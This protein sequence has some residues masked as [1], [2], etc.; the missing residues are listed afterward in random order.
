MSLS[1]LVPKQL[2]F[3][4]GNAWAAAENQWNQWVLTY[5]SDRQENWVKRLSKSLVKH[6]GL[7]QFLGGGRLEVLIYLMVG[8]LLLFVLGMAILLYRAGRVVISPLDS[9]MAKLEKTYLDYLAH[10]QP[11]LLRSKQTEALKRRRAE[12]HRAWLTRLSVEQPTSHEKPLW[13]LMKQFEQLKYAPKEA[14]KI[15]F[16]EWKKQ[17][18]VTIGQLKKKNK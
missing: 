3:W 12:T 4:A 6:L 2:I 11:K 16:K 10:K 15:A 9:G 17:L 5:D 18:K 13:H 1:K 7:D 8:L 14:Q